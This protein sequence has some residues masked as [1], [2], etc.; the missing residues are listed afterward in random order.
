MLDAMEWR[1]EVS[2]H[3]CCEGKDREGKKRNIISQNHYM[4]IV[5]VLPKCINIMQQINF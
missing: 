1:G 2:P 4:K 3:S 5:I